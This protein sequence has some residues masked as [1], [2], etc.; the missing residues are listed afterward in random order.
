MD[1]TRFNK[2]AIQV[3]SPISRG[4]HM[5]NGC[6]HAFMLNGEDIKKVNSVKY[7]GHIICSDSK[8]PIVCPW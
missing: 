3:K 6:H 1:L 5:K 7:P 2:I 4:K 8:S